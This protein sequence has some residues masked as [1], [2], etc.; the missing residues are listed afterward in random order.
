[1]HIEMMSHQ[2]CTL[3]K[4]DCKEETSKPSLEPHSFLLTHPQPLG[5]PG[6]PGLAWM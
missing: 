1:M 4:A 5:W 6:A 3:T 2:Y